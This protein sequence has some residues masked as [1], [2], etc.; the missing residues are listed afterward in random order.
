MDLLLD[1]V[2]NSQDPRLSPLPPA[3]LATVDSSPTHYLNGSVATATAAGRASIIILC[4]PPVRSP[5]AQAVST[6]KIQDIRPRTTLAL[7][8]YLS[9]LADWF[10]LY[11]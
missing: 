6:A 8:S 2:R 5:V 11:Y 3:L 10:S 1:G 7:V 4:V 9:L